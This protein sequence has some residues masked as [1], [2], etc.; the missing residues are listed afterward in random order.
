MVEGL[1][2][3]LEPFANRPSQ[4]EIYENTYAPQLL[5]HFVGALTVFDVPFGVGGFH[6]K[7]GH[8]QKTRLSFACTTGASTILL[9]GG[10][11]AFV[12][13][14]GA[15]PWQGQ[16]R[17]LFDWKRP[18]DL[19]SVESVV[20][21][22][23]LELMGALYN[24]RHPALVVFTNGVNIVILQPWGSLAQMTASMSMML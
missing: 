2:S 14:H 10:T 21:Q 13:P 22:A 1:G 6:F 18:S 12:I 20:T 11:D 23:Q 8:T 5:N 4:G 15:I 17:I 16:T 3:A 19:Q 24:S 7:D 9:T